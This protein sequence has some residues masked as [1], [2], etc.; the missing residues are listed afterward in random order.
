M[1]FQLTSLPEALLY[2]HG[3]H[4]FYEERTEIAR[5]GVPLA[6]RLLL[7]DSPKHGWTEL[8]IIRI[9]IARF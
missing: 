7:L 9:Q 5:A 6:G 4:Y 8:R 2:W 1:R 3:R